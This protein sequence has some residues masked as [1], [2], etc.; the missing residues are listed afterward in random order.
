METDRKTM[1]LE[2]LR[3]YVAKHDAALNGIAKRVI[4]QRPSV[5]EQ[6]QLLKALQIEHN[7]TLEAFKPPAQ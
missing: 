2:L 3:N 5:W 6:D 4:H 1:P 7:P